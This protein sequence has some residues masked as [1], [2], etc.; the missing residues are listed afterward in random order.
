MTSNL[1][2][3]QLV[4]DIHNDLA[5]VK[6]TDTTTTT[7]K[8]FVDVKAKTFSGAGNRWSHNLIVWD[9]DGV[10]RC[11]GSAVAIAEPLIVR[12]TPELAILAFA[13]ATEGAKS[14]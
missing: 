2:V 9:E 5:S 3:Q 13:K 12:Y 11:D 4:N 8:L 7:T 14:G 1:D 6:W 10:E